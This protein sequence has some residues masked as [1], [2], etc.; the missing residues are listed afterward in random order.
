RQFGE[1]NVLGLSFY[2]GDSSSPRWNI[3]GIIPDIHLYS[4]LD[5]DDAVTFQMRKRQAGLN[6]IFVRV[7]TDNPRETMKLVQSS[8]RQLEPDN[9]VAA[10][11]LSENTR[12]WYDSE[13]RLS[14]IFFTAA[15]I[16]IVLS[17]LGLFAIVLLV[18]EQRRKEIGV[19]KVLGAS[20]A[21]LTGLLARDFIRLVILAFF[22]ATPVAWFFLNRWLSDFSYRISI[23][24][25][26]F[27][28][29][30]MVTLLIALVTISIQTIK[31]AIA[32][33]A[34]SLRAE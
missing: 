15:G 29:A 8:L 11:W 1:K 5:K 16:A 18:M 23:G 21:Q 27:P 14:K 2:P 28:M 25:W 9:V 17:C 32:N 22:V 3:I 20:I 33:P 31:A 24:W 12:R 4:V 30:G 34:E 19:R 7:R 13:E 26:V 6:F 10:S